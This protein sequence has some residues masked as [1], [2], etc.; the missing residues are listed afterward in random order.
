MNKSILFESARFTLSNEPIFAMF[1]SKFVD[2]VT[3]SEYILRFAEVSD[4]FFVQIYVNI[5]N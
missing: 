1:K 4:I 2:N 3:M 5:L